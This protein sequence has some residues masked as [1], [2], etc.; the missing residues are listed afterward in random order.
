MELYAKAA[1]AASVKIERLT[2]EII[3]AAKKQGATVRD[4]EEAF[5]I[6]QVLIQSK[7]NGKTL[8]ELQLEIPG[9]NK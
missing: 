6:V 8:D 9:K 1:M 7:V 3:E 2:A 4:L 5:K